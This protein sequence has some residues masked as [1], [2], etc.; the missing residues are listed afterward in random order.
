MEIFSDE[1]LSEVD[2]RVAVSRELLAKTGLSDDAK[3]DLDGLFVLIVTLKNQIFSEREAM[4]NKTNVRSLPML[5]EAAERWQKLLR[6]AIRWSHEKT[7]NEFDLD[8]GETK[9]ECW[10]RMDKEF[11]ELNE[12]QINF[13]SWRDTK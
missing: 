9:G 12:D 11:G 13:L 6:A 10:K 5:G 8:N 3:K 7:L 4:N 2:G 1:L